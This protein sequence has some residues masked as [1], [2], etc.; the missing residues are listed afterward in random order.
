[1]KERVCTLTFVLFSFR[2]TVIVGDQ[3]FLENSDSIKTKKSNRLSSPPPALS[4][5]YPKECNLC[6]KFR[7]QYRN[8]RYEPY[9]IVTEDAQ[10]KIKAA[11]KVKDQNL[12]AEINHLDL[13][14]RE[15]KVHRHCYQNFTRDVT[16]SSSTC[17]TASSASTSISIP[18]DKA[19]FEAVKNFLS[20]EVIGCG[21]VTTMKHLHNLYDLATGD[22]RYRNKLKERIKKEY[23]HQLLFLDPGVGRGEVVIAADCLDGKS[24]TECNVVVSAAKSIKNSIL[25]KFKSVEELNWL[26]TAEEL[27]SDNRKPPDEVFF[28]SRRC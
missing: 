5:L 28:F 13:I 15:F 10:R 17:V 22:S 14:S 11:A 16:E 8:K 9:Q 27:S 3:K 7:V 4:V 19:N 20:N 12:Y 26:P 6:S 1:M 24:L 21:K 18:Y 23:K 25:E 2:Y